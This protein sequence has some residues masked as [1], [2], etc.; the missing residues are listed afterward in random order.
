MSETPRTLDVRPGH[1]EL[2]YARV[3]GV[4]YVVGDGMLE[5]GDFITSRITGDASF[6]DSANRIA[7]AEGMYRLGAA[8]HVVTTLTLIWLAVSF[9]VVLKSVD[10]RL[11][12]VA[13]LCWIVETG[14]SALENIFDFASLKISLAA[15]NSPVSESGLFGHFADLADRM[16]GLAF[17]LG[18]IVFSMGS[19]IFYVLFLKSRYIPRA[20]AGFDLTASALIMVV[21]FTNLLH[22]A[23]S[24]FATY[25]YIAMSIA[26]FGTGLWLMIRGIKIAPNVG[27]PAT[28]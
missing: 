7:A 16:S 25:G 8:C 11:A 3:A 15:A 4:M 19:I 28:R 21:G 13:L 26:E 2:V 9:Y 20:I 1:A 14:L 27:S 17:N 5:L 12:L 10:S 23:F 18:I 6:A 22:P 24:S